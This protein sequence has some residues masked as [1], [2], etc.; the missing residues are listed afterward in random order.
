MGLSGSHQALGPP[1]W[2]HRHTGSALHSSGHKDLGP[3]SQIPCCPVRGSHGNQWPTPF[4]RCSRRSRD[5]WYWAV[6]GEP[7]AARQVD[8]RTL[9][10]PLSV[11]LRLGRRHCYPPLT[12]DHTEVRPL[13]GQPPPPEACPSP[14]ARWASRRRAPSQPSLALPRPSG[15]TQRSPTLTG[16][17]FLQTQAH[18]Q[19]RMTRKT[20][21]SHN[22]IVH[23]VLC[24]Y[25]DVWEKQAVQRGTEDNESLLPCVF[26]DPSPIPVFLSQFPKDKTSNCWMFQHILCHKYQDLSQII[27]E[28][29]ETDNL[30]L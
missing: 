25:V 6:R 13:T 20:S 4:V 9:A 16:R 21:V 14:R 22:S 23:T 15:E 7:G 3:R 30:A 10:P 2:N 26:G 5:S 18:V 24:D 29:A 28:R 17:G 8:L 12:R 19:R 11:A 27:P 1:E